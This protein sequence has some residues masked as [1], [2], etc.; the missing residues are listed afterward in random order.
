MFRTTLSHVPVSCLA[1]IGRAAQRTPTL[2]RTRMSMSA[3]ED[4][5]MVKVAVAQMTSSGS[6]D[7]N[8]A[9]CSSLAQVGV[10]FL[11]LLII[12]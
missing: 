11:L 6:V 5:A 8:L 3:T 4:N 10:V 9:T 7:D 12:V 2:K 1:I